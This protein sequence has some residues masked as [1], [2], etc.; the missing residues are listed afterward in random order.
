MRSRDRVIKAIHH[1]ETDRV[2]VD[3]GATG[4]T[5]IHASALAGLRKRLGSDD[6]P[7]F[8]HEPYQMLGVVEE[9]LREVLQVDV[10]GLWNP[11]NFL[12]FRNE[13]WKPWQ[14]PD[15]T[16]VMMGSGFEYDVDAAGVTYVYPQGDRSV[17][18]SAKLPKGGYFFDSIYRNADF[19]ED[20]LDARR[21]FKETYGVFDD[22]TAGFLEQNAL[23]LEEETEFAVV[24]NFGGGG[25][26]D[27]AV[28]AG[29]YEKHP[30]GIRK[31]E[32]WLMAHL[33]Y[34]GYVKELFEMQTEIALKNLEIYRQ[35]VG[36]RIQVINISG[37]DF[38]SQKGEIIS[39]DLYREFY[40][41]YHKILNDWVHRNTK[42]KTFYHCCGSIV[43]L[44]DDMV[45]AGVDILNPVQCSA[46]GMDPVML[47]E[48]YGKKLVFWGGGVDT[49]HTLPFGKPEEVKQEV[50]ERLKIF[51][52]GGGFV[53]NTIHNIQGA[54]PVENMAA[55]FEA[56]RE[57]NKG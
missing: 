8:V 51:S 11:L 15:G 29:P 6:G 50:T 44:L 28:L 45:E 1:E 23:F 30:R 27:V 13:N 43:K 32:D 3:L 4:Q 22:E 12:G 41:P 53:F 42:W 47:K 16:R 31:V 56:V 25:Y 14:L 46:A 20:D 40:K 21:D 37:T 34:P 17:P 10:V 48:K 2:P 5:G 55:M 7:V 18:P 24:G 26:G 36:D 52:K 35:A 39:P 49:Q 38:G 33:L 57:F 54:T 19:D 9:D